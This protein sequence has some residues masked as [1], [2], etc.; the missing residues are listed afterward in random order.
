MQDWLASEG[1]RQNILSA[2]VR[3]IGVG[4]FGDP[5][6]TSTVR[7][8]SSC[9][10]V[11]TQRGPYY[12]YWVQDFGARDENGMPSLPLVINGEAPSTTDR[13]VSLYVYGGDG[14]QSWATTVQFSEDG[15]Q[16]SEPEP[17]SAHRTYVLS[18]G[19]GLKT[20]YA[21]IGNGAQTQISSDTIV[22]LGSRVYVPLASP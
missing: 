10:S 2:S 5:A 8:L 17:W 12:H 3:E 16:W 13:Q 14:G 6:D 11:S 1:H 19:A 18:E 15:F 9:P 22:L 20:V 4:Y 21:R 7:L